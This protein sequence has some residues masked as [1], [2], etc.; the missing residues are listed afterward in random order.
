[1]DFVLAFEMFNNLSIDI[2][3]ETCLER[4]NS[5]D[6]GLVFVVDRLCSRSKHRSHRYRSIAIC[7]DQPERESIALELE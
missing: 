2:Q 7:S 5:L 6:D 3:C 4:R 1:M